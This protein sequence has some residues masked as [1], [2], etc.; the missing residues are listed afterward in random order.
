MD[1]RSG[2]TILAAQRTGRVAC[3]VEL[4][5]EYVDVAIRRFQQNFK[6]VP[7]VLAT[8][9]QTFDAVAAERADLAR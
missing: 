2:S 1:S 5:P 9:G 3:A 7:V 4:A 8:T 6:S